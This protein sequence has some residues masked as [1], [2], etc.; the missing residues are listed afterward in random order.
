MDYR[1]DPDALINQPLIIR[2]LVIIPFGALMLCC[3]MMRNYIIH[4]TKDNGHRGVVKAI[5]G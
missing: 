1:Y 5:D 4:K 2:A 3:F